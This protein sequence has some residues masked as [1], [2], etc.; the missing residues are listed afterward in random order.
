MGNMEGGH[1]GSDPGLRLSCCAA[2]EHRFGFRERLRSSCLTDTQQAWP[3][4]PAMLKHNSD[5][6]GFCSTQGVRILAGAP[7]RS[8]A[9]SA[10]NRSI[11]AS[12]L[13]A[14]FSQPS[15]A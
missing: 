15:T 4:D 3:Y 13:K 12:G 9:Y 8:T 14:A 11:R 2:R 5:T 10:A 1:S 7:A 6:P